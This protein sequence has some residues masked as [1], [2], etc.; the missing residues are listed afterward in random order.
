M[1]QSDLGL[2]YNQGSRDNVTDWALEKFQNKY[3]PQITKGDIWF[4]LYGVMHAT[5]WRKKHQHDLQR[6]LPRIPLANNFVAFRDSGEA[7]M[8]LHANYETGPE[9]PIDCL[10]DGRLVI[11]GQFAQ[12]GLVTPPPL[13]HL[14]K[15]S[16]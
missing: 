2:S 7:L 13:G 14:M 6:E 15:L 3:G 8:N 10:V 1:D 16:G 11:D 4:Y 12:K 5:D 9:A